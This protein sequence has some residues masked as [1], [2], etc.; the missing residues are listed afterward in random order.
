MG[1]S[2]FFFGVLCATTLFPHQVT[3]SITHALTL[4][5]HHSHSSLWSSVFFSVALCATTFF[6]LTLSLTHALS[7]TRSH[8]HT[9][10]TA[11]TQTSVT[12]L[13][14]FALQI[15][16]TKKYFYLF[17]CIQKQCASRCKCLILV[18]S[19]LQRSY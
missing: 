13:V 15:N 6:S 3:L 1:S 14:R 4:T 12:Q 19:L 10:L 5:L 8:S 11:C 2:L 17:S 9:A 16:Q 7:N 18:Q